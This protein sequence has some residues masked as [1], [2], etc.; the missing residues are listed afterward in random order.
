MSSS[1]QWTSLCPFVL[2]FL[3]LSCFL[4]LVF[5]YFKREKFHAFVVSME[6][7]KLSCPAEGALNCESN[8]NCLFTTEDAD[9]VLL[10]WT[11]PFG[12][13]F[14]LS[15]SSFNVTRCRLADDRSLFQRA[16]AIFFHHPDI[17]LTNIPTEPRPCCQKWVWLNM[18]SPAN[19][20]LIPELND[21]FNLTCSYRL[22]S[23]VPVPYGYL[24]PVTS[25]DETFKVREKQ[26]LVCWVVSNWDTRHRRVQFYNELK[27]HVQ[28]SVFGDGVGRRLSD[29]EYMKTMSG[30]KFYLSFEAHGLHHREVVSTHDAGECPS[31]QLRGPRPG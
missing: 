7:E 2:S 17:R 23:D 24:V 19:S 21:L 6:T 30:C 8:P 1:G 26:L 16:D 9:T 14:D 27:K 25:E 12:Q 28:V 13:R 20:P 4:L 29:G 18:E 5:S 11:W 15:C 3:F 31:R 22:D 10:I